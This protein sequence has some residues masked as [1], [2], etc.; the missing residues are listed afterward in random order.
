MWQESLDALSLKLGTDKGSIGNDYL[1]NYERNLRHLKDSEFNLIEIGLAQ[2]ASVRMWERY[3]SRA[4]IVGVDIRDCSHLAG[5]R[6]SI[7]TG[8]QADTDFLT[9][10]GNKYKPLV[11]IDD[12]SHLAAHNMISFR[13][14]FPTLASGGLYVIEDVHLHF[15]KSA[16]YRGNSDE[17]P[18]EFFSKIAIELNAEGPLQVANSS[19]WVSTIERIEFFRRAILIE[20]KTDRDLSLLVEQAWPLI[21]EGQNAYLWQTMSSFIL[22]YNLGLDKA[23]LAAQRAVAIAPKMAAPHIRL[24]DIYERQGRIAEALES[25]TAAM[26]NAPANGEIVRMS[27][28]LK[29]RLH[30]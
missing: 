12:G 22:K 7:E 15:A 4:H 30:P 19:N 29:A 2:G 26:Q 14:L 11:V 6:I 18:S 24:A 28:R 23:A 8:S 3:F 16:E 10:L 5:G 25:A 13:S 1:V 27:E 20:R 9:N 21:E 17:L